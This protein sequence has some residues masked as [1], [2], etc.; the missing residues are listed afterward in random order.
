MI[1]K[2]F[3]Y[4]T[5]IVA[6]LLMVLGTLAKLIFNLKIDSDWFWFI[7][8]LA[9][10]L[11]GVIDLSKQKQFSKK[12]KVIS[13]KEFKELWNSLDDSNKAYK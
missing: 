9:L 6:G 8:G 3:Q 4:E 10:V 2:L 5:Y 1:K 13:K 11:E 12:Y 7:A